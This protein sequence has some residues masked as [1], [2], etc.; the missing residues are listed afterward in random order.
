MGGSVKGDRPVVVGSIGEWTEVAS[1]KRAIL[2][3]FT[4]SLD[5]SEDVRDR[6]VTCVSFFSCVVGS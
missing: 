3:V 2:G 4:E 1:A 6:T 5:D